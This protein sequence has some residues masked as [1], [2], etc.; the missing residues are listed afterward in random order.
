MR[1]T[2]TPEWFTRYSISA[3]AENVD[4]STAVAP[5]SAAP[6][7]AATASGRLP[8]SIPTRPPGRTPAAASPPATFQDCSASC[9]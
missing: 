6:K 4:I 7:N 3:G 5:Q 9:E 2:C 1:S 8:M